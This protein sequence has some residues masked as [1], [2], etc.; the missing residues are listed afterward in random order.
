MNAYGNNDCTYTR[1]NVEG[2]LYKLMLVE[3][4]HMMCGR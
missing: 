1:Y 2:N 3:L 4:D